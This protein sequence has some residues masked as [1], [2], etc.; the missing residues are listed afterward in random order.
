MIPEIKF[1]SL[2]IFSTVTV[3][4]RLYSEYFNQFRRMDCLKL[5]HWSIYSA[6]VL[7]Q[8]TGVAHG[9]YVTPFTSVYQQPPPPTVQQQ[10]QT[11][12]QQQQTQKLY[13]ATNYQQSSVPPVILQQPTNQRVM[14]IPLMCLKNCEKV[15]PARRKH[16]LQD[17]IVLWCLKFCIN[18]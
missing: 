15:V 5:W 6:L 10:E 16:G 1:C 2:H 11:S 13:I 8:Q 18:W 14:I 4:Y 3:L 12:S 17:V 7:Q 9:S